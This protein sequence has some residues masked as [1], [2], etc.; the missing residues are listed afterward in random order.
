MLRIATFCEFS[1]IVLVAISVT[2]DYMQ[3]CICVPMEEDI[4]QKVLTILVIIEE[5][6]YVWRKHNNSNNSA[7]SHTLSKCS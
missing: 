6:C 2:T 5:N 3:V 7:L 4:L 1:E